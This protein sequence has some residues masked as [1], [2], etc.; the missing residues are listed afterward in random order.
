V[1]AL[2]EVRF[3]PNIPEEAIFGVL[4]EPLARDFPK[5]E[6]LPALQLPPQIRNVNPQ[7]RFQSTYRLRSKDYVIAIGP[8]VFSVGIV[9][10]YPGWAA[11]RN[12]LEGVFGT[13]I[14]KGIVKQLQ[15]LG[16]RYV[17]V[18]EGDVTPR[19]TLQTKLA[20]NR[21][22][23]YKTYFRTTL[24][25]N[26][27]KL[28]LQIAKDQTVKRPPDF[29]RQGTSID[30]DVSQT[31]TEALDLGKLEAFIDQAHLTEKVLFFEL[32]QPDLLK[33]LHPAY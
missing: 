15:R 9:M 17:N 32:L 24:E 1:D 30:I 27:S 18:F 29:N 3:T 25:R 10:P 21:I 16:L 23:G 19:L 14:E 11:F 31:A 5:V 26:G 13:L 12:K 20:G 28:L 2:V 33:E 8:R 22:D 6:N 4:Y 7:L